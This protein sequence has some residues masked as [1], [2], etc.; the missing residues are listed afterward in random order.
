MNEQNKVLIIIAIEVGAIVAGWF[1]LYL[2]FAIK[3]WL[4]NRR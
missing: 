3:D 2:Y 1:G 4:S